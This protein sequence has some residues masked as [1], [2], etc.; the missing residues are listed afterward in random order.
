[1]KVTITAASVKLDAGRRAY[2]GQVV[3][4][5]AATGNAL[6]TRKLADANAAAETV[7]AD[8]PVPE[9]RDPEIA[10]PRRGRPRKAE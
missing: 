10:T 6:I 8:D 5:D 1:M 9:N 4:V 2:R 7:R 3:E